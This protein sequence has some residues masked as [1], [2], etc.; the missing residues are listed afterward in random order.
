MIANNYPE[1]VVPII[2]AT[3]QCR[4]VDHE[5]RCTIEV[6]ASDPILGYEAAQQHGWQKTNINIVGLP[7]PA[8]ILPP[9]L[10]LQVRC[11]ETPARE[12]A[13]WAVLTDGTTD[14]PAHWTK[15][16]GSAVKDI[17]GGMGLHPPNKIKGLLERKPWMMVS[18]PFQPEYPKGRMW[19]ANAPQLMYPADVHASRP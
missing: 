3:Q 7:P 16:T 19:N 14:E 10:N 18:L 6:K 13:G 4:I 2:P 11:L 15:K 1:T 5:G 8:P 9:E 17:L 12:E